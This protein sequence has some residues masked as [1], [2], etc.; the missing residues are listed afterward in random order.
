MILPTLTSTHSTELSDIVARVEAGERL[1]FE[2]GLRL[3]RSHDLLTIGQLADLVNRRI[4]GGE[5]VYFNQ[6]RH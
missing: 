2:D 6:N 4:N 1:G 3:F 5:Y